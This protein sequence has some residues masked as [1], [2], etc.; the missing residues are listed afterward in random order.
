MTVTSNSAVEDPCQS[1]MSII[2]SN[3][4]VRF[5][6]GYRRAN[7]YCTWCLCDEALHLSTATGNPTHNINLKTAEVHAAEQPQSLA[8]NTSVNNLRDSSD[9]SCS[10]NVFRSPAGYS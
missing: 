3:V 10:S 2:G 7:S 9:T 4:A 8:T 5:N 6:P 1:K